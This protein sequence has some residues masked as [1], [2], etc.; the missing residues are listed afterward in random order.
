[1]I[2]IANKNVGGMIMTR[3]E[4]IAYYEKIL[5]RTADA[6]RNLEAAL[7]EYEAICPLLQELERYYTGPEWKA[8]YD[9]DAAGDLPRDL[10]RGVLSEDGIDSVLERFRDLKE[11]IG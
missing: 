8:D 1:M 10:K 6:I 7:D 9:A 5:D 11:R 3:E 4:R 2:R